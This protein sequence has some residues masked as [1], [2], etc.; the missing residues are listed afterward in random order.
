MGV[1]ENTQFPNS[2]TMQA[3]DKT[4]DHFWVSLIHLSNLKYPGVNRIGKPEFSLRKIEHIWTD[5]ETIT[6][7]NADP[8]VLATS[9]I[10]TCIFCTLI[11]SNYCQSS[12]GHPNVLIIFLHASAPPPH[13]PTGQNN[14]KIHIIQGKV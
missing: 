11:Y 4:N 14:W 1:P 10:S 13:V 9:Q 5:L 12:L 3:A 2:P 8:K 6:I 7:Y